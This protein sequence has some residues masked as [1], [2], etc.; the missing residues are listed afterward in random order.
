MDKALSIQSAEDCFPYFLI[1]SLPSSQYMSSP[2]L[3][4]GNCLFVFQMDEEGYKALNMSQACWP[5]LLHQKK[6]SKFKSVCQGCI[7][8]ICYFSSYG[9]V[10][11]RSLRVRNNIRQSLAKDFREC[12][13]LYFLEVLKMALIQ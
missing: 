13:S 6:S 5:T 9:R 4:T 7:H 12:F 2:V 11:I 10:K 1:K 3:E 8:D